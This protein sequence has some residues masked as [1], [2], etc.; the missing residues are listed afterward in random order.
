[1]QEYRG[2]QDINVNDILGDGWANGEEKDCYPPGYPKVRKVAEILSGILW[3]SNYGRGEI[4][5]ITVFRINGEHYSQ[6]GN[7]R[8]YCTR[9]LGQETIKAR[10]IEVKYKEMLRSAR[11]IKDRVMF[12]YCLGISCDDGKSYYLY[13]LNDFEEQ[14]LIELQVPVLP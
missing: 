11:L 4:P 10:V 1:M 12:W 7:H 6:E 3:G 5:P 2:I 9:L 13:D 14:R 8:L